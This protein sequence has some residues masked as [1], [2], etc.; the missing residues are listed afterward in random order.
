MK[1]NPH[2]QACRDCLYYLDIHPGDGSCRRSPPAVHVVDVR[3]GGS[4]F[5]RIHTRYPMVSG[6]DWCGEWSAAPAE[7]L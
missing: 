6:G 7:V 3:D 2:G 4:S 5:E 1:R